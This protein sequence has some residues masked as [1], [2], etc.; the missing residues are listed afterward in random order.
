[1]GRGTGTDPGGGKLREGNLVSAADT[2]SVGRA[3]PGASRQVGRTQEADGIGTQDPSPIGWASSAVE[4]TN[5]KRAI[6]GGRNPRGDRRCRLA[7]RAQDHEGGGHGAAAPRVA[8]PGEENPRRTSREVRRGALNNHLIEDW[9]RYR[10]SRQALKVEATSD[11]ERARV[12]SAAP[13]PW[14]CPKALKGA[15]AGPPRPTP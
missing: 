14:V 7:R 11:E 13:K 6:A 5:L 15:I 8:R 10:P 9:R 3:E 4:T 2:G 1:M 12:L